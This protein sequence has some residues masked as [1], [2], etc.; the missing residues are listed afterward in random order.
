MTRGLFDDRI[1]VEYLGRSGHT[2]SCLLAINAILNSGR[3]PERA[4][5]ITHVYD[6]KSHPRQEDHLF[7]FWDWPFMPIVVI[8]SGFTS[9]YSGEGPSG[10][11]L[12]VCL[13]REKQVPTDVIFVDEQV[14]N[15]LDKGKII[16]TDDQVFKDIKSGS[17]PGHWPWYDWVREDIEMAL[18]R[19]HIWRHSYLEWYQLTDQVSIAVSNIDLFDAEIGKKLRL[20][21]DKMRTGIQTE[22]W[23]NAGL[24]IRD[25]WIEFAKLLCDEENIDTSDIEKDKVI[26]KLKKLKLDEYVIGL[27]KASFDLSLKVQHDRGISKDI[28]LACVTASVLSMQIIVLKYIEQPKPFK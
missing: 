20:A 1:R 5:I 15:A 9:G 28:A 3:L 27:C 16:Y 18:E 11:A 21:V 12:A 4:T 19:G 17:E 23:Q 26:N 6:A 24:L 2:Q 25:A 22:D 7:V 13:I 14:F 10:F 8:P